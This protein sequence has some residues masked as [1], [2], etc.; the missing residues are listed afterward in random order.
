VAR[1]G[2]NSKIVD[3]FRGAED[4]LRQV[5]AARLGTGAA[6]AGAAGLAYNALSG[7]PEPKAKP[8]WQQTQW[9]NT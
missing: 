5:L 3:S 9:Y 7:E 2:W 8:W 1:A 6:A 4:E